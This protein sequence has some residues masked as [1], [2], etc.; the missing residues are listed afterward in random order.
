EAFYMKSPRRRAKVKFARRFL[1]VVDR[2]SSVAAPTSAL[3][4]AG[5]RVRPFTPRS[6]E[7]VP[8][9]RMPV[10][11]TRFRW[12]ML[13]AAASVVITCGVMIRAAQLSRGLNQ[14]RQQG[15]MQDRRVDD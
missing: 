6:S 8:V 2:A 1:T 15:A 7:A 9:V 11:P 10:R 13:T 3:A 14:A 5:D 4:G 12:S